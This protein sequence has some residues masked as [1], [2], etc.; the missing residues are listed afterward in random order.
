VGGG[1]DPSFPV[2][3]ICYIA[4]MRY[5]ATTAISAAVAAALAASCGGASERAEET[6]PVAGERIAFFSDRDGDDEIYVM[7]R[8][9]QRVEQ[10]THNSGPEA[11]EPDDFLPAWSPDGRSIAF[12]STR[13]QPGQAMPSGDE[14]APEEI[15]VMDAD[16]GKEKRLTSN[17][18][19]D[20]SP[21]WTPDGKITFVRCRED[22]DSIGCEVKAVGAEGGDEETLY[23]ADGFL[24]EARVSPDGSEL[25]VARI[26][27]NSHYQEQELY[28]VD[29]ETGAERRVTT[30]DDGDGAPAWSP[31][32]ERLAFTSNRAPSA[33]CL[34]HDC[35]GWT[36]ELYVMD[37]DGQEVVRLTETPHEERAS[38]WSPDGEQI[39]YSRLRD[40]EDDAELYV[41]NAD[42]TCPTALT[43]NSHSDNSGDWYG[44]PGSRQ[45]RLDC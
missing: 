33:P 30:N 28:V 42:G 5:G 11:R 18:D 43:D 40:E 8:D 35:G 4:S 1:A 25:A 10:L 26:H 19:S 9:G 22:G 44:P 7:D 39:L 13:D 21:D 36:N 41:M 15:Y 29:L 16:G 17:S 27:G 23:S 14:P 3:R 34:F 12:V 6:N 31:D 45:G 37:A 38:A 20:V 24:V 32:G 2:A